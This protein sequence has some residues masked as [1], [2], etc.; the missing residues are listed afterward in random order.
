MTKVK[1][2][3]SP[4]DPGA[5]L[6]HEKLKP[7]H[8]MTKECPRCLGHGGWNL[9]L[10]A[11]KMPP[12]KAFTPANRKLYV[13]FNASCDHCNGWGYVHPNVTCPGHQWVEIKTIANCLHLMECKVCKA[14][15]EMDSS[16]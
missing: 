6:D 3:L 12:G 11:Y 5:F 4:T 16:D 9:R 8:G 10:N 13:H 7:A 15:W 14:Q 2:Y 1:E